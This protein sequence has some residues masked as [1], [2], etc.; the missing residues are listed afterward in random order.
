MYEA[1]RKKRDDFHAWVTLGTEAEFING[2]VVVHSPARNIHLDVTGRLFKLLSTYVDVHG[3]GTAK[4]EKAMVKLTRNSVEP[5]ICFFR[6]EKAAA[7]TK[8][9]L[10]FPVPDFVAEVLSESTEKTDRTVKMEDYALHGVEEYWLI[11]T[12][13]ERIEQYLLHRGTFKPQETHHK[14]VSSFVVPGFTVA[15]DDVFNGAQYLKAL[16]NILDAFPN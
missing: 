11:D 1:E 2:E 12:D 14:P 16:K 4:M 13:E 15:R 9:T 10:F 8:Q 7:V 6:K 3:L 5:D